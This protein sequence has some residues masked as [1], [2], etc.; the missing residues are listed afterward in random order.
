MNLI[1]S[2]DKNFSVDADREEVRYL[3]FWCLVDGS[4]EYFNADL[5]KV[6]PYPFD[7]EGSLYQAY[8]YLQKVY[9]NLLPQFTRLFN[10]LHG[11]NHNQRYWEIMVGYWL[12]EYIEILYERYRCVKAAY[13]IYPDAIVH[14]LDPTCYVCPQ[15]G[16]EFQY[17]CLGHWY[18]HQLYSQIIE[19][20]KY[21]RAN[22]IKISAIALEQE[23]F[24]LC[25]PKATAIKQAIKWASLLLSRWNRIY[26]VS[27]YFPISRLMKMIF[28]FKIFPTLDTPH[29]FYQRRELDV[30]R[31]DIFKQWDARD[32]FEQ[33]IKATLPY[34]I[35]TVYIEHYADLKRKV[36]SFFPKKKVNLIFTA[37]GSSVNDGFKL[38]A[39]QQT[40]KYHTPFAI[41]QHGGRAK[42]KWY[43]LDDYEKSIADYYLTYGW[44]ESGKDHVI[45]FISNRLQYVKPGRSL[46]KKN[47]IILWILTSCPR[48]SYAMFSST[49]G[50]QFK[51][52]LD[53]QIR[54]LKQLEFSARLLLR[55]RPF[56]YHYG[57][58]ELEYIREKAGEY[59]M[60]N[61]KLSLWQE[62]K[63]SRLSVCTYD[64]T[65]NLE[66]WVANIPQII[67]WNPRH[68]EMSDEMVH[69]EKKF[70]DLGILHYNPENAAAKVNEVKDNPLAWW[71]QPE[72][73]SLR[74]EYCEKFARTAPNSDQE[75]IRMI[76]KLSNI[77]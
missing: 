19:Y 73:Q 15:N 57:W 4:K 28:A 31:R 55:A 62:L 8:C 7:E 40:E 52:Y 47:G 46:G 5:S 65:S 2:G 16:K 53:E 71:M 30:D 42:S 9:Q 29:F 12:R 67:Y 22:K 75:W 6:L 54:F 74:G 59:Q 77:K 60:A 64:G 51:D 44:K 50:P 72:I 26:F 14:V 13:L 61:L 39:A 11:E 23:L 1:L 36:H 76:K 33:L 3:G 21:F 18:N 45:P 66:A 37:N 10:E 68:W 27:T 24:S 38:W 43:S 48:Y 63:L 70:Y 25:V 34:N 17:F 20:F 69:Y 32:E 56:Y 49:V 35:P 58:R 41:L